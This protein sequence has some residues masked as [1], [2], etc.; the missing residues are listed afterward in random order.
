MQSWKTLLSKT[1]TDYIAKYSP[2]LRSCNSRLWY[3][4]SATKHLKDKITADTTNS[5][6]EVLITAIYLFLQYINPLPKSARI[7]SWFCPRLDPSCVVSPRSLGLHGWM[8]PCSQLH[9]R[10]VGKLHLK[11]GE[12]CNPQVSKL[13]IFKCEKTRTTI[14]KTL[15]NDLQKTLQEWH[16]QQDQYPS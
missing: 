16:I 5:W 2:T 13:G 6:L 8:T 12:S 9:P 15:G 7:S 1:T 10:A 11:K 3:V 14:H 4:T